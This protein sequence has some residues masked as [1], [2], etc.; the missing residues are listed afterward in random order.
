[1]AAT[2]EDLAK[3]IDSLAKSVAKDYPDIDWEDL[4]QEMA[5]F[6]VKNG[7]SIKLKEDGGNPRWL[8]ERVAKQ[9][10]KEIRTQHLIL[11]AQY[12]YRPSDVKE[13]LETAFNPEARESSYVPEDAVSLDGIDSLQ[14]SS[15]VMAAYELLKPEWKE[16]IF[17]RYALNQIPSNET[18]ERKKLNKAINELTYRLN[19]YR[20]STKDRRKILSNAGARAAYSEVYE[21]N[22]SR[23]GANQ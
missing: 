15:D 3:I 9:A 12:A 14:I 4:R 8:M 18:Y 17:R 13:I 2:Y 6:V 19:T 21:G 11:T 1:M 5:I 22:A 20:G 10:A 7:K 23:Y 16:V